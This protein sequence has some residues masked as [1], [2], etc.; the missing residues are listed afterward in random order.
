MKERREREREGGNEGGREG[1][2]CNMGGKRRREE[3]IKAGWKKDKEGEDHHSV[4][5]RAALYLDECSQ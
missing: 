1:G 4:L 3:G 2:I 5:L